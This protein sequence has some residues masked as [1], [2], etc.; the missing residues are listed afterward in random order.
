ML[1]DYTGAPRK[2]TMPV[3]VVRRMRG[4]GWNESLPLEQQEDWPAHAAFMENLFDEGFVLLVGPLEGTREFLLVVRAE[5]AEE[6]NAR[7]AE[8]CWVRDDVSRIIDVR[9]WQLRLG[10]LG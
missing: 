1:D 3:F 2:W 5:T 7:L 10:S 6:V 9:P 4:S 8:D